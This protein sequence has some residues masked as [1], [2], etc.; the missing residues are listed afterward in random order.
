MAGT[1]GVGFHAVLATARGGG[2]RVPEAPVPVRESLRDAGPTPAAITGRPRDVQACA[3]ISGSRRVRSTGARWG[4]SQRRR[5][6][7]SRRMQYALSH[8][9]STLAALL[10]LAVLI[11]MVVR[12][13]GQ[14]A[15]SPQATPS[16]QRL[17][18]YADDFSLE[19]TLSPAKPP[20]IH[21]VNGV[22]RKGAGK[23]RASHY[24]SFTRLEVKGSITLE[25]QSFHVNGIAWMDH[26]FS[27]DSLGPGQV[28]WDWMSI[29]LDDGSELMLYRMRRSDGSADP[30]SSG[31][32]VDAKG[33]A[34]HLEWSQIRM[35]AVEGSEWKSAATGGVYP[36]KWQIEVPDLE[37]RLD[38]S[39]DLEDQEVVSERQVSP[40]YWEGAMNF[41]GEK[42]GRAIPGAGYLEM[43]GY[44]KP[45]SIGPG[46]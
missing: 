12:P 35:T 16:T 45:L 40:S 3:T 6:G 27:T 10:L 18:A 15:S 31:T 34:R 14:E 11:L 17:T 25:Q 1:G 32:Y 26:E 28:G 46:K 21:G 2:E 9:T 29:Q 33:R 20:V 39:T 44:D 5:L 19:L 22:S 24:I 38:C 42:A 7:G 8:R 43:T 30:Y 4:L 37:I 13:S 41:T 23:G 36:L